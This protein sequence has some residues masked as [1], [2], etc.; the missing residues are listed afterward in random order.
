MWY[1][2]GMKKWLS[3]VGIGLLLGIALA[4]MLAWLTYTIIILKKDPALANAYV[5]VGT[6]I[7]AIVTALLVGFTWLNIR[8]TKE[9]ERRD[10]EERLLNEIIE[11]ASNVAKSAISRQAINVP[12]LWKAKLEYKFHKSKGKYINVIVSSSFEELSDSFKD[13]NIKLDEAIDFLERILSGK[14]GNILSLKDYE[15]AITDSVEKF[16]E[17]AAKIKT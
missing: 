10:S 16:L 14:S 2:S 15:T 1:N 12:E 11:W 8:N 4:F 5:A 6:L 3:D 9:K 17:E 13:A 7:L